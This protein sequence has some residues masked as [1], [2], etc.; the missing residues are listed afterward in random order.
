VWPAGR[1]VWPAMWPAGRGVS[2]ACKQRAETACP[3][4]YSR[5]GEH[6]RWLGTASMQRAAGTQVQ[7]V[8]CN[9][10]A[11]GGVECKRRG[12]RALQA[13][14]VVK[15]ASAEGG[16]QR[17]CRGWCRLRAQ[18]VAC[19]ASAEGGRAGA[20][21]EGARLD[22]RTRHP[23]TNTRAHTQANARTLTLIWLERMTMR[24]PNSTDARL[25]FRRGRTPSAFTT[26]RSKAATCRAA[27]SWDTGSK[28]TSQA[29]G[30][31]TSGLY[32]SCARA[33]A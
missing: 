33:C 26:R 22:A 6:R 7:R 17:K 4:G 23:C 14:R 5:Q 30:P 29:W 20:S 18:R 19:N 11:E 21:A 12:W 16:V 1:R 32:S 9:A 8:A 13:Q 2:A 15:I 28:L 3:R 25:T 24:V 10:S 31:I 27:P